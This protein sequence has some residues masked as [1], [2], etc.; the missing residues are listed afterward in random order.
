MVDWVETGP[1]GASVILQDFSP[2]GSGVE[3]ASL[4]SR[5]WTP[6]QMLHRLSMTSSRQGRTEGQSAPAF[7]AA[8]QRTNLC[9]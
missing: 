4:A 6:R 8:L 7:F 9:E 1:P 2:E 3:H 5:R